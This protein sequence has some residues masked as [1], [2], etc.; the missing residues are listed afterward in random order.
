MKENLLISGGTLIDGTG[1]EP[2]P[3]HH[4]F[5]SNGEIV[6]LGENADKKANEFCKEEGI[7]L[8][9]LVEIN[10][11]GKS[12][13]PGLIDSHL[14]CS[15]D[16]VQSNDELFFHR[17]P[18]MVALVASQNLK[19]ILRSGVTSFVDPDTAH[20]IG[21]ALRDAINANVIEGPRMK[22]GVQALLTAVGG[23]AG[24]LIPDDG[25]VGYAQVVNSKDEI[26]KWTRRHIK[27]GAD[28]IKIHATGSIPGKPGELLVWNREELRAACETAHELSI[29]VMAHC[30]GAESVRVCA[31]EGV[32]LILHASF[33]DEQG[34]EAV[35]ENGTS[36]CPTFTF[37]AN[38]ADFGGKVG[39]SPGMEDIFRGEIEETAKMIRKAYDNGV[40]IVSGSESGFAL[41]PYGHW[42]ARELQVFVEVLGLSAVEAIET[43]TKNG[44]WV[45]QMDDQLGTLEVGRLADLLIVD[46]DPINDISVLNDKAKIESIN[47]KGKRVNTEETWP[48]H[49]A[50]PGWKVGNWAGEIL[51]W[52]KAYD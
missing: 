45:M 12:V 1:S 33:M 19:K 43:A 28:W 21:P 4:I 27:Y 37:L 44:A 39:A 15:F 18:I 22:T 13:M 8:E 20:G 5:I 25:T 51:T 46:G 41:T 52:D 11:E 32:D 38:L 24:R 42:H 36:I 3:N 50:I 47:S 30:R 48:E 31:E 35:L 10:A 40:R 6:A 29:P 14:H 23:T 2:I 26:V 9:E 17:D 16:D 7:A 34:L 49:K